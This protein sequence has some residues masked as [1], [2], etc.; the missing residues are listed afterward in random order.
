MTEDAN[1]VSGNLMASGTVSIADAD[2]NQS[3][4]NTTTTSAVGNL[5]TLALSANGQYTYTVANSATQYL[6]LGETKIDTFTLK[7]ADGTTKDVTFTINGTNDTPLIGA[8]TVSSVT[9]DAN[10]VSYTH[11]TLPTICS[12]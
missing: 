12:V 2:Q 3:S 4:F 6:G 9:E 10:A 1:A 8:P 7:T 5:G 11:L